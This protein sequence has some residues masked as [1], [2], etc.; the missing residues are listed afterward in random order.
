MN[1]EVPFYSQLNDEIDVSLQR[2]IC[3][4]SCVKMVLEYYFPKEVFN[5]DNLIKEAEL[6]KAFDAV[7][8][9][10]IHDGLV[11]IL[12]NHSLTAYAQ[13]FRSVKVDLMT[14]EFLENEN[15][16]HI[17]EKGIEKIIDSINDEKPVIV[18]VAKGFSDNRDSHLVL[19]KGYKKND[20]L[21]FYVHDPLMGDDREV[22][23][24][25]FLQYWR[26][27]VIFTA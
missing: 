14:G 3:G 11:R 25:Y 27:F 22:T 2:Q 5:I 13:E 24:E 1:L 18:S 23:L 19:I 15:E 9:I 26:K 6:I 7:N 20:D 21:I 4:I 12:R 8:N 17:L 16:P 10:W